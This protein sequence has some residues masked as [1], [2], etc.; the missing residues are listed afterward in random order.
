LEEDWVRADPKY[1]R[2]LFLGYALFLAGIIAVPWVAHPL[3]QNLFQFGTPVKILWVLE[4]LALAF[5]S[6]FSFPAIYLIRTGLTILRENR[7][8]HSR[9]RTLY[10]TPILRGKAAR[11]RGHALISLGWVCLIAILLGGSATHFIFYKFKTDPQY[12]VRHSG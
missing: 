11:R 1:R 8:P 10:D 5:L 7:M 6:L 2:N 12:F 3:L 9:M 4:T